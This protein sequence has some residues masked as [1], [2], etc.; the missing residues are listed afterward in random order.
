MRAFVLL[1]LL[2]GL[3]GQAYGD[4][5]SE[6]KPLFTK[7]DRGSYGIVQFI[8]AVT[9][10]AGTTKLIALSDDYRLALRRGSL[11]KEHDEARA[12]LDSLLL[13]T[14]ETQELKNLLDAYK[15]LAR[16]LPPEGAFRQ[17]CDVKILE[18]TD[19]LR[20]PT[21]P[22]N[23][24][25]KDINYLNAQVEAA[26]EKLKAVTRK[27]RLTQ[28][29]YLAALTSGGFLMFQLGSRLV[30]WYDG[31]DPGLTPGVK[32]AYHYGIKPAFKLF[33]IVDVDETGAT[34]EIPLS[35]EAIE[36]DEQESKEVS[37]RSYLSYPAR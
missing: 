27:I 22:R 32:L 7:F 33:R 28:G 16:D 34:T 14:S 24:G 3:S 29:K 30:I 2:T 6:P 10:A 9:D 1:A 11:K 19:Q 15:T 21:L 37:D 8:L 25:G 23:P 26:K 31:N 36:F 35:A 18:I 13:L 4:E 12:N 17:S 5:K 20:G